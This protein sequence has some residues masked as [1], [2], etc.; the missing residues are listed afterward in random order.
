MQARSINTSA[1]HQAV[2][3]RLLEM[4]RAKTGQAGADWTSATTRLFNA[5]Y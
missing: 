5:L 4:L 3:E 2:V 1:L